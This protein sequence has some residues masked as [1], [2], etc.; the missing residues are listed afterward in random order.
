MEWLIQLPGG[1]LLP[2]TEVINERGS[3]VLRMGRSGRGNHSPGSVAWIKSVRDPEPWSG[4]GR[5]DTPKK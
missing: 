4:A 2:S 3:V 1:A 5:G